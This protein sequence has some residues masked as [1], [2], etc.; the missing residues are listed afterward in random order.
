MTASE[1]ANSLFE[2][3][4]KK[5]C[6]RPHAFTRGTG[7]FLPVNTYVLHLTEAIRYSQVAGNSQFTRSGNMKGPRGRNIEF[8]VSVLAQTFKQE[9]THGRK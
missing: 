8:N 6:V 1:R 3:L 2:R 9:H 7:P 5:H 4:Q